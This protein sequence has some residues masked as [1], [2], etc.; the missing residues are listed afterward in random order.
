MKYSLFLTLFGFVVAHGF[1]QNENDALRYS[2]TDLVGSARSQAM[3]G[4]FSAVGAD[5]GAATLN[6]A[7]TALYQ[8]TDFSL[9]ARYSLTLNNTQFVGKNQAATSSAFNIPSLGYLYHQKTEVDGEESK[10][11]SVNVGF[12]YNQLQNFKN[13]TQASAYNKHS[14]VT[15]FF[16]ASAQGQQAGDLE[17]N[18]QSYAGM[19]Y[20]VYAIDTLRGSTTNYMPAFNN[21]RV[22][23]DFLLLQSGNRG[24]WYINF[25]GNYMNRWY[26]GATLGLQSVSYTQSLTLKESDTENQHESYQNNPQANTPLQFP[27]NSLTFRDNFTTTGSGA[28]L[29]LGVIYRPT[30]YFRTGLSVK[31]PTM[32][33][34]TDSYDFSM[35]HDQNRASQQLIDATSG[36]L[37]SQWR[38]RTPFQATWGA[39]CLFG[40]R[41]F[42]SA[43]VD[44]VDYTMAKLSSRGSYFYS[45]AQENSTI[46]NY[47][48][49]TLTYRLGGELRL[50]KLRLRAGGALISAPVRSDILEYQDAENIANFKS[51]SGLGRVV[52]GG[53]GYRNQS[54]FLDIA[55]VNRQQNRLY[56]P[57]TLQTG[58]SFTPTAVSRLNT[59]S[60]L[61]TIGFS[62]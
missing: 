43:D 2:T 1:A 62:F 18:L 15:D 39:M 5:M 58:G 9:T 16:A 12:G 17:Q 61:S 36:D 60:L 19:A 54:F 46:R 55:V 34:M 32:L 26:V 44:F 50:G 56:N 42:V 53:I 28:N 51:V 30:D 11:K 35:S 3:G 4:A 23:Q 21:G 13:E 22:Q 38:L 25:S 47:F 27:T 40:K 45:Y 10:W 37:A 14:S 8:Y 7:G 6:P 31:T 24:E 49:R 41:G 20:Y 33:S 29:Q 59:T 57:Y 52:T 48:N